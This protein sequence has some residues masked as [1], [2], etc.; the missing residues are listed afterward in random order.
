MPLSTIY[1]DLDC[2]SIKRIM[3]TIL[4]FSAITFFISACTSA[5]DYLEQALQLAGDNRAEL[6]R[7][8]AHYDSVGDSQKQAAARFLIENMP[9]HYSYSTDRIDDYY[10][11]SLNL[12]RSEMSP[13]EQYDSLLYLTKHKFVGLQQQNIQDVRIMKSDYLIKNIDQAFDIWR[14]G[15]YA[16]HLTFDEFC[17]WLLPYKI[18]EL[19]S[20][21]AWRDTMITHYAESLDRLYPNDESY[22]TTFRALDFVRNDVLSKLGR[23][24]TYNESTIEMRSAETLV[25]MKFGRCIDFVTLGTAAFRSLGLPVVIDDVPCYGRFRAGHAWFTMLNDRGE[26]LSSEWDLTSVPGSAFFTNY[27]FPKIF[28]STY[29]INYD[30]LRY[31]NNSVM[32]YPFSIHKMDVTDRYFRT[33]D[34]RLPLPDSFKKVEDYAYLAVFDGHNTVWRIVEYGEIDGDSF[35]FKNIGRNILYIALGFDGNTT[36]PL[37][38][39]FIVEKDGTL[40]YV[41]GPN[42]ERETVEVGRKY[43]QSENVVDMRRRLLGGKIEAANRADFADAKTIITIDSV[44]IPDKMAT[45]C[46]DVYRYWRYVGADGTYGSIAELAFFETDSI[47]LEGE[48]IG[49]KK[50]S[51]EMLDKAFDGDWLSNFEMESIGEPDGAWVGKDFG[52]HR[53]VDFVRVVPRSDDNDVHPGREYEMLYWDNERW[54]SLGKQT[55]EGN[56]VRYDNV[57]CKALLWL[58]C[59]WG[60]DERVFLYENGKQVW[61]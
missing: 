53:R 24:E 45:G 49:C 23:F 10:A 59:N 1:I 39:P 19:Q 28:R 37:S 40:T 33:S 21:D 41:E 60:W 17:E 22:Y 5:P 2:T 57:P 44:N 18:T 58:K 6:E 35:E 20:L 31:L 50:A 25:N 52:K 7:V 3:R 30:R 16:K 34:I 29:A 15:M 14:N 61:W 38:K 55:A 9:G 46:S 32:K 47:K 51:K 48:N 12:A 42:G 4:L 36:V 54:V 43:F 26:E 27:T 13:G 11:I 8:I 56:R